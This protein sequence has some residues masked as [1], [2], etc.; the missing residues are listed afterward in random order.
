MQRL[1]KWFAVATTIGML[2]VLIGGALVTKTGSGMGCGR[3]WPL[4]HGQLIPSHIT[5]ELLIE[6]SHRVVSGVVGLM[7]LILS[8]WSWKAI[9]HIR[10]TKFYPLFRSCFSFCKG[11]LGRLRSYGGN[12]T[13]C[14]R[15][16][17]VSRSFRLRLSFY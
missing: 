1:L 11:S 10:E 9:G 6:L 7:V 8:I 5:T 3:S 17:L 13:S 2:F 12:R 16:I 4:C 15:F 14:L